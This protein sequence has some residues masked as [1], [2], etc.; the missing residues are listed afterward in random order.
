MPELI[1]LLPAR[2]EEM[3]VIEVI[4]RLPN[5]QIENLGFSY[6]VI[7]VD[8][9]STDSTCENAISKG[10]ELIVQSDTLGKGNGVREALHSIFSEWKDG[11]GDL[12]I[13]LDADA[14]YR[15]EDIPRFIEYLQDYEVVWGSRLRGTM[16]KNAMSRTNKFGNKVLSFI[17]SL[18]FFRRTTDLC[19][20]FWGFRM[21]SLKKLR[22]TADGFNLEADL[23]GS[24]VKSKMTTKE[25]PVDYDHRQGESNLTWYLDGPR[26][27]LMAIRKRIF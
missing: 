1:V 2:N 26:I 24:V 20:G 23:F 27:L 13:M 25:I 16:E 4:D 9:N 17:A 12:L 5:T 7:V 19:T 6:R 10:A 14:T 18:L 8:G 15:P 22:L 3:G 21:E 11:A